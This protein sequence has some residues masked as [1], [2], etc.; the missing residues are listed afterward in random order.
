MTEQLKLEVKVDFEDNIVAKI[1][2]HEV[3]HGRL[4]MTCRWQGFTAE[5][6]TM[7]EA[8]ELFNSSCPKRITEYYRNK[9]T[10]KDKHLHEFMNEYFP[11]LAYEE[12]VEKQRNTAGAVA[13]GKKKRQRVC[14]KTLDQAS[15]EVLNSKNRKEPKQS[16]AKKPKWLAKA[17]QEA[18]RRADTEGRLTTDKAVRDARARK[19]KELVEASA[20][21]SKMT[22]PD[23]VPEPKKHQVEKKPKNTEAKKQRAASKSA[24]L[25]SVLQKE[26]LDASKRKSTPKEKTRR[27]YTLNTLVYQSKQKGAG[28]GLFMLEK[29]KKGYRVAV[30]AGELITQKEANERDSEYI[31]YV[32]ENTLLDENDVL[33]RKGRHI[34]HAGPGTTSNAR[35]SGLRRVVIDPIS[36]KPCV[37]I[38]ARKT[39]MQGEEILISYNKS[40]KWDWEGREQAK[41]QMANKPVWALSSGRGRLRG[42]GR[43]RGGRGR[44]RGFHRPRR[45]SR[46]AISRDMIQTIVEAAGALGHQVKTNLARLWNSGMHYVQKQ[47]MDKLYEKV[48]AV[49]ELL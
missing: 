27:M 11:S 47:N 40:W 30:Y 16:K 14:G 13:K 41:P 43:G 4:Y 25:E 23:T 10:K 5:M 21:A 34:C 33:S 26:L 35:I 17:E 36:R 49:Y 42:R 48:N 8:T 38:L 46:Y 20:I 37:S 28:M 2:G 32:K 19:R 9:K 6:D 45:R 7:Q 15:A 18:E 1:V 24:V 22:P 31:L 44:G 39:I 12:E 3:K 29:A